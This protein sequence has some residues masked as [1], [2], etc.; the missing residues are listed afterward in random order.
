MTP[1]TDTLYASAEVK[2]TS[3]SAAPILLAGRLMIKVLH[4]FEN[5]CRHYFS[6]K[7]VTVKDHIGKVIYNFESTA[8]Q[9]WINTEEAQ[10]LV[11]SFPEFLIMLK[12]KF[13]P[14][15]WEDELVQDQI[16]TQ[17]TSSFLT[18]VNTVHNANHGLGAAKSK[19]HIPDNHFRL[20]LI[21]RLSNGMKHLYKANNGT[22]PGVTKGTLDAITDF[23]EWLEQLQLLEQDLQATCVAWIAQAAKSGNILR[24]SSV[25]NIK[26]NSSPSLS[27]TSQSTA[28][29]P[30]TDD[31]RC[32]YDYTWAVTSAEFSMQDTLGAIA[33]IHTPR[34]KTARG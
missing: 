16:T 19:Y 20:H 1:A 7:D 2:Q 3:P 11:L 10:L 4:Q 22:A 5:A 18:W 12:K 17:G 15:S 30:L 25:P 6:M 32:C 28:L 33:P 14:R 8:I 13:L 29:N 34:S 27:T 31:G 21:P 9:S 23:E 26:S 24:D